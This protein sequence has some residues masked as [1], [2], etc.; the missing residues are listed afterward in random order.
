MG[1]AAL[2]TKHDH[3]ASV[4]RA[5]RPY[6][7]AIRLAVFAA[8]ILVTI[9]LLVPTAPFDANPGLT[10][11]WEVWWPAVPLLFLLLGPLWCA[12]CPF[13]TLA[14]LVRGVSPFFFRIPSRWWS[15]GVHS[16]LL[17]FCLVLTGDSLFGFR[18]D[19][20]ATLVLL[21]ALVG[22]CA[23]L[24]SLFDARAYCRFACPVNALARVYAALSPVRLERT[25]DACA[26]CALSAGSDAPVT[27]RTDSDC[28]AQCPRAGLPLTIATPLRED[29]LRGLGFAGS[30]APS[31]LLL[32]MSLHVFTEGGIF[33]DVPEGLSS[34]L[35]REVGASLVVVVFIGAALGTAIA[36][37][38]ALHGALHVHGG[39]GRER[40]RSGWFCAAL[41]LP[42]LH[43]LLTMYEVEVIPDPSIAVARVTLVLGC[44]WSLLAFLWVSVRG[45][46][47]E[48]EKL[49]LPLLAGAGAHFA[50]LFVA[51]AFALESAAVSG[52]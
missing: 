8:F 49:P 1:I 27:A 7:S 45:A 16:G 20:V 18:T 44:I 25:M 11:M 29:D 21:A 30:L 10:L 41:L 28:L 48:E 24:S 39:I 50:L 36:G 3:G 13:S 2:S 34:L 5:R 35:H 17:S 4:S 22:I 37:T 47:P 32:A 40:I 14:R 52:C 19:A 43:V 26:M 51:A 23:V 15:S 33:L 12:V 38:K 9:L 6:L 31:L 42:F 46:A